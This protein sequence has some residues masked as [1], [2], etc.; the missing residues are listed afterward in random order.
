MNVN[1]SVPEKDENGEE[2]DP[3]GDEAS[4]TPVKKLLSRRFYGEDETLKVD[5]AQSTKEYYASDVTPEEQVRIEGYGDQI[6]PG[7]EGPEGIEIPFS[8]FAWD[9]NWSFPRSK[10]NDAY[11]SSIPD[12]KNHTNKKSF[13]GFKPNEVKIADWTVDDP[14]PQNEDE[15]K[16][17]KVS[18]SFKFVVEPSAKLTIGGIEIDKQ[19]WEYVSPVFREIISEDQTTAT[20]QVIAVRVQQI[21]EMADFGRLGIS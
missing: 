15:R 2:E 12:L 16:N 5:T 11:I 3:L 18:M 20:Q 6:N 10:M 4:S 7:K 19:G 13:R 21:Y 9:E 1:Y 14:I 8:R 17:A